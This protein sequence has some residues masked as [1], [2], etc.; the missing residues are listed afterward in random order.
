ML[1]LNILKDLLKYDVYVN[2]EENDFL[3]KKKTCN[4]TE[5]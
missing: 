4:N 5:K 2:T 3:F 1:N